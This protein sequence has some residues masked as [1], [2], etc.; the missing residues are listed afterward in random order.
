M[1]IFSYLVMLV[2]AIAFHEMA[3]AF[4]ADR[5]GDDTSRLYN[6]ISLNPLKHIDLSTTIILPL[7]LAFMGLPVFGAAKPVLVNK[8]KIRHGDYGVA[9]VAIAG[10]L[11]NLI[12]SFIFHG[13]MF[14]AVKNSVLWL[15][16]LF[17]AGVAVNLGFFLFN[18]LPLPPLDGSRL[19]YAFAPKL[20][21]DFMEKM[22]RYQAIVVL[23]LIFL[24]YDLVSQYIAGLSGSMVEFYN[25]FFNAIM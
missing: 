1:N 18:M 2:L 22:E 17:A 4:V 9:L 8:R 14:L 25:H 3:H 5:L 12:L 23:V 7:A 16:Q 6:R 13:F 21:Q 11:T 24:F 20:V 10:P 15:A 19:L